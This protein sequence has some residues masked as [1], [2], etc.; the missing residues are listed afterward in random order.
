M[1]CA[2]AAGAVLWV[3]TAGAT[4]YEWNLPL[5]VAEPPVP[6]DNPITLEKVALGRYLFYDTRLSGNQTQACASCHRQAAAFTDGLTNAVGSTG[7]VHPRSSMS[8]TNVA[9]APTL[10]WANPL[11][12]E[13]EQ[14]ALVPMFGERPVELGL[15]GLE[16]EL[17]ARLRADGRYRRMFAEAFP[18]RADPITL[19]TIVK[20]IG[21]F[22][23]TLISGNS[24]YDR[25]VLGLEALTAS[26]LRGQNNFFSEVA[27]C[28]HCHNG[29][30]FTTS[31]RFAGQG[32]EQVDF[33]NTGLYNI[34]GA[35]GYPPPNTGL[36]EITGDAADM[37]R[38]KP[39]TLRNIELTAPY[40]HDGSIAT[41]E[42]AIE[43][44]AAGGR[45]I[46]EGPYAGI[47][48][49]NP[50]KSRFV[51]GFALGEEDTT[52]LVNFLKTLTDPDFV[53]DPR[54]ADPFPPARCPGDCD[55]SGTVTVHELVTTIELALGRGSL[56]RCVGVEGN[57]DGD[58]TID[59]LIH[60]VRSALEGCGT[61]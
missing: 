55:Y 40:M 45:T 12:R 2:A 21:S 10:G 1:A 46:A 5:T 16:A 22:G 51:P 33:Q 38:F 26:E 19:D 8:L 30:N 20:A 60:V 7:E 54:H 39:P 36:H 58:V 42:E 52:D 34:D 6:A 32:F 15:T 28:H 35:G 31:V 59:E 3:G 43:H 29:F 44:Y 11:L 49:D 56:A 24:R 41:L 53:T 37:G 50:Y 48:A 25:F 14:Q 61:P 13:L 17:F 47:G 18:E 23:R 57:G 9:Y 27:E 4:P